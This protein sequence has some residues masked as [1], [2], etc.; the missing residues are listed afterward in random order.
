[1]YD[2]LVVY[3]YVWLDRVRK[4]KRCLFF[5]RYVK[6]QHMFNEKGAH[7]LFIERVLYF[8]ISHSNEHRLHILLYD[9]T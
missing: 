9:M 3:I 4:Y 2:S 7:T 6:T 5:V 8:P 1:M